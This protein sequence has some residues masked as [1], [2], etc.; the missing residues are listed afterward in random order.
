MRHPRGVAQPGSALAF[1]A[2]WREFTSLHPDQFFFAAAT[3][4]PRHTHRARS[5]TWIEHQPS[6]LGVVGSSPAGRAKN[7]TISAA[8]GSAPK[9][10]KILHRQVLVFAAS[11]AVVSSQLALA[12]NVATPSGRCVSNCDAPVS[13]PRPGAAPAVSPDLIDFSSRLGNAIGRSL[14]NNNAPSSAGGAS[15][16]AAQ[17]YLSE[18]ADQ[19]SADSPPNDD[20]RCI[21][22]SRQ[23]Q[24]GP[25]QRSCNDGHRSY[26]QE[27]TATNTIEVRCSN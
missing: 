4:R 13:A 7:A 23:G 19:G 15:N 27:W 18:W 22:W 25:W 24:D 3:R 11:L 9:G 16:A 2:R 5:S 21:R 6:K 10:R 17:Q 14:T 1:G 12:Q 8:I 20:S 26:C